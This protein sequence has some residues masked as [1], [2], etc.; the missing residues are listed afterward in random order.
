[1][2]I[3]HIKLLNGD[4]LDHVDRMRFDVLPRSGDVVEFEGDEFIYLVHSIRHDMRGLN[5]PVIDQK[6]T[7]VL[8][9]M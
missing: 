1:M 9:R 2:T 4:Q 6:I 3:A 5:E 7:V 8:Y